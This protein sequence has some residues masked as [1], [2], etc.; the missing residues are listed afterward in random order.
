MR[1]TVQF[2]FVSQ[3]F[4]IWHKKSGINIPLVFATWK[5]FIYQCNFLVDEYFNLFNRKTVFNLVFQPTLDFI[6][7]TCY[8][9][10][11]LWVLQTAVIFF[12]NYPEQSS[13]INL[14]LSLFFSFFFFNPRFIFHWNFWYPPF[15]R[16]VSDGKMPLAIS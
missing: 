3:T 14:L 15:M 9:Y 13:I 7:I 2:T 1:T 4:H 12:F 16:I 11:E 8:L 6:W 5:Y 10:I